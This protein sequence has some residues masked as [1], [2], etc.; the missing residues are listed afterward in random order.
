MDYI[1][2]NPNH[3]FTST[4]PLEDFDQCAQLTHAA[5]SRGCDIEEAVF[6]NAHRANALFEVNESF[7]T[8][9]VATMRTLEYLVGIGY[10]LEKQD[11]VEGLTPLLHAVVAYRPQAINCIKTYIKRGADIHAKNLKGQGALH[12][13]L[14]GPHSLCEWKGV[15]PEVRVEGDT[16][17]DEWYLRGVY[18]TDEDNPMEDYNSER[19]AGFASYHPRRDRGMPSWIDT[20]QESPWSKPS[21]V[22]GDSHDVLAMGNLFRDDKESTYIPISYSSVHSIADHASTPEDDMLEYIICRDYGGIQHIIRKPVRVLKIR[23]RYM[24]LIL[25]EA[26]YDPNM[27]DAEGKSPNDYAERDYLL[28]QWE[29]ALRRAGYVLVNGQWARD[30]MQSSSMTRSPSMLFSSIWGNTPDSHCLRLDR[31]L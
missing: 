10:D 31:N 11:D 25:L 4:K 12:C 9:S 22:P 6:Y 15:H 8:N 7:F 21:Y 17:D 14:T 19:C 30:T 27:L 13:A 3:S 5:L 24:L 20:M 2:H 1:S 16:F 26:G 18:H 29:W 23:L 28:P